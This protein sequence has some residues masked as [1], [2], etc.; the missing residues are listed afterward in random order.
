MQ[1]QQ[2]L[3]KLLMNTCANIHK[4]RRESLEALVQSAL[5]GQRLT[6]TDL[7]RS[8]QSDTSHK[9][10][11]KQADR[12]LSNPHIHAESI[13]IYR[14]LYHQ[15]IGLQTRPVILI[16][17]SDMDDYKQHFV[18]RATIAMEGRSITLYQET[19]TIETKEKRSSHRAF[20]QQLKMLLP[21]TCQPIL[22]TDAG[23]RTTWF[24]EVAEQGWD[25]VG[26]VRNRHYMR[27]ANGGRWFNAKRCYEKATT[28]PV[29]LGE[30]ILTQRNQVSCQFVLYQGK[31]KGRK[32]KNR[33]GDIA[34]NSY[35]R[36]QAARQREPWLLATSLPVT[37]KLAKK[38]VNIYRLRMQIEES[39][40]DTKSHR[41]GLSLDYHRCK[42]AMRLQIMLLISTLAS[43]VFW[44]LGLATI[45]SGQHRQFQANSIKHK[46]VLSIVFIGRLVVRNMQISLSGVDIRKA[47]EKLNEIL[48]VHQW[49]H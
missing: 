21:M 42:S 30:G 49:Q 37:S 4:T 12:L 18:L 5:I 19:H 14:A 13:E 11:I 35:S 46:R 36:K 48:Y 27:W 6:V 15:H 7:G 26:R 38:I 22:V 20:L 10:N 47:W 16:D 3:H 29:Y 39:F 24:L 28:R 1:A 31:L 41:F 8:I 17:W 2:V 43:L 44:L 34:A 23:F 33:L 40:K 25:W 9:H 32:H 45:I